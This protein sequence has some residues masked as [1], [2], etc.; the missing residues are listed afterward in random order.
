[1]STSERIKAE[2]EANAIAEMLLMPERETRQLIEQGY[3]LEEMA[4][5][6][7]VSESA[8]TVR[9]MNLGYKIL[10]AGYAAAVVL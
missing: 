1:M 3:S 7:E 10:E 2:Q 6:F 9:V 5:Y 4:D 8:M